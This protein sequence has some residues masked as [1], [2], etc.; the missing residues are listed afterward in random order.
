MVDDNLGLDICLICSLLTAKCIDLSL[1]INYSTYFK[2]LIQYYIV[3]F[4]W[5]PLN[6]GIQYKGKYN[7]LISGPGLVSA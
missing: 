4:A 6:R 1:L 2:D 3:N 5:C 7:T